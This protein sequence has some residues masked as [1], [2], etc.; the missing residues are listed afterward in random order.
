M[1]RADVGSLSGSGV[2]GTVLLDLAD[3]LGTLTVAM[4]LTVFLCL[5]ADRF[6]YTF[7]ESD[8]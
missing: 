7:S 3:D 2:S 5:F 1:F 8:T 4:I 6:S